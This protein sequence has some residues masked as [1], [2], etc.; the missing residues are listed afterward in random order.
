METE[1]A[2]QKKER[3]DIEESRVKRLE[4]VKSKQRDRGGIFKPAET[5]PLIDIL[6]ARDVSG[7]SPTKKIHTQ[8]AKPRRRSSAANTARDQNHAQ[9]KAAKPQATDRRKSAAAIASIP[10]TGKTRRKS[11]AQS[12]KASKTSSQEEFD[13]GN[14]DQGHS[15]RT[16]LRRYISTRLY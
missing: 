10:A 6:M 16:F 15:K 1:T 5:N 7:L 9:G 2:E 11:I 12:N 4:R 3:L 8:K 14:D 13:N